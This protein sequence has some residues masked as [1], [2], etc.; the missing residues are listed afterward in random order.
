M[1]GEEV[2]ARSSGVRKYFCSSLAIYDCCMTLPLALITFC[3]TKED[4]YLQWRLRSPTHFLQY[5]VYAADY[6]LHASIKGCPFASIVEG[7]D[8]F[9][10][11][12]GVHFCIHKWLSVMVIS[13][14]AAIVAI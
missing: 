11:A 9:L 6:R 1:C 10:A 3:R 7:D 12:N 14:Y 4:T 13:P 8:V 5:S 2:L